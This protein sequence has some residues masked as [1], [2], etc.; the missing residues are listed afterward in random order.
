MPLLP[1]TDEGVSDRLEHA[2]LRDLAWLLVTPDVIELSGPITYSGRPTRQELGLVDSVDDWL[3]S[4]STLVNALDGKLATRMGHY[5]E[6][7]WHLM[8]DNA[9]NTRLL[10]KNLRITQRR[11]TLG[12]LDMLYRT[13][14]NPNP[15]HLEVA[16]KFY[17][18]LPEGP[19]DATS[20]SR[21]IGPG[22]LDSLALKCSHLR[23][24]QL[25]MSST[26]IAQ[27]II[28]QWLSPRD[29]G[30]ALPHYPLT[31]RLAMPGVLFY[32]W[33]TTMPPPIGATV[34]HRRGKWCYLND[35][36]AL[37]AEKGESLHMAWLEKPHWLAPPQ[38]AAFQPAN[39]EM[40]MVMPLIERYGPQQ[41][42]LYDSEAETKKQQMER[43]IIVPNDWPRQVPLPPRA[44]G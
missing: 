20:Q 24:H 32:P 39:E 4:L 38:Q 11:N 44:R 29:L 35:W 23:H 7:L 22:G 14:N 15:I 1:T 37:A 41:V 5:H 27:A 9:P 36:P 19:G 16:I 26:A 42:M 3:A 34:D 10:A 43:L 17:L 12:E 28:A 13:R 31:Q 25:P 21:W 30:H 8:L 6:R 33:H 18:G 2:V 40:A